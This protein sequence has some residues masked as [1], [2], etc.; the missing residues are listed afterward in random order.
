LVQQ[1]HGSVGELTN[2]KAATMMTAS[3]SMDELS[4]SSISYSTDAA[5]AATITTN[6]DDGDEYSDFRSYLKEDVS[7]DAIAVT[8]AVDTTTNDVTVTASADATTVVADVVATPAVVEDDKDTNIDTNTA[9]DLDFVPPPPPHIELLQLSTDA[10]VSSFVSSQS[11]GG[12]SVTC[13]AHVMSYLDDDSRESARLS[14]SYLRAAVRQY[15]AYVKSIS[16]MMSTSNADLAVAEGE[17][18]MDDEEE[19]VKE[20]TLIYLQDLLHKQQLQEQNQHHRSL[21]SLERLIDARDTI[22]STPDERS[23]KP[24]ING[25]NHHHDHPE[26]QQQHYQQSPPQLPHHQPSPS[27]PPPNF[28]YASE[29]ASS[30]FKTESLDD[31]TLLSYPYQQ[32]IIEE[33]DEESW[34]LNPAAM[35][36]INNDGGQV[37]KQL[38]EE[39]LEIDVRDCIHARI[40]E[41]KNNATAKVEEG[42]DKVNNNNS[43]ST[44]PDILAQFSD[45]MLYG[46]TPPVLSQFMSGIVDSAKLAVS[47]LYNH[48]QNGGGWRN[49]IMSN[50]DDGVDDSGPIKIGDKY[51]SHNEALRRWRRAKVKLEDRYHGIDMEGNVKMEQ[52][53]YFEKSS[54]FQDRDAKGE[55]IYERNYWEEGMME[56]IIE[57]EEE[58]KVGSDKEKKDAEVGGEPN[59]SI[60]RI[61]KK[62][63]K[64]NKVPKENPAVNEEEEEEE[65]ERKGDG[66]EGNEEIA[67]KNYNGGYHF[68]RTDR[69]LGTPK[70]DS[71][72]AASSSLS[73]TCSWDS[74]PTTAPPPPPPEQQSPLTTAPRRM[75]LQNISNTTA[76]PRSDNEIDCLAEEG[77]VPPDMMSRTSMSS[78]GMAYNFIGGNTVRKDCEQSVLGSQ[79]GMEVLLKVP[80]KTTTARKPRSLASHNFGVAKVVAKQAPV[81]KQTHEVTPPS[82]LRSQLKKN[83]PSSWT[84]RTTSTLKNN[85]SKTILPLKLKLGIMKSVK[86]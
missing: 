9:M 2:F 19:E 41:R 67:E 59:M 38:Q 12:N 29:S 60:D 25:N 55:K 23:V 1:Q 84:N 56:G 22:P 83:K 13:I 30:S 10:T 69:L 47:Q 85:T 46:D 31:S 57:D 36:N 73:S 18:E 8:A 49:A 71:D 39:D 54:L 76:T 11:Y 7:Y 33:D 78:P 6:G 53:T 4:C 26:Q 3:S 72:T 45:A 24:L 42:S 58:E 34:E 64:L 48:Q 17:E 32:T 86:A 20:E 40:I 80:K 16:S 28:R 50:D 15:H 27:H 77:S 66:E 68:K 75:S 65:V 52:T 74:L 81:V 61:V 82:P 37:Q 43:N 21:S 5:A 70:G 14:C 35:Q 51:Y 79:Y 63:A 62:Y 44:T